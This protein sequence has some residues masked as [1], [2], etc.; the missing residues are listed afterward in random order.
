MEHTKRDIL[1]LSAAM[2]ET[3]TS[4]EEVFI[5]LDNGK[6]AAVSLLDGPPGT[7]Q[8]GFLFASPD[9]TM[10]EAQR[11]LENFNS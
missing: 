5:E 4:G 9:D 11:M 3:G 10:S 6:T 2:A 7:G 1:N 8:V